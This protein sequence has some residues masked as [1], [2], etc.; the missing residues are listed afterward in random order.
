MSVVFH[1]HGKIGV[2]ASALMH[3]H[4]KG[5]PEGCFSSFSN[6]EV[7]PVLGVSSLRI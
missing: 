6:L 7:V 1:T 2:Q 3:T 4:A 5:N